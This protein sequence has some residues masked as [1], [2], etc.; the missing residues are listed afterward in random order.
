MKNRVEIK[1]RKE[2]IKLVDSFYDKVNRDELLSPVFNDFSRVDWE[3]HLPVMYN[4]WCSML[5]GEMSYKGA[6]FQK[7]IPLPI[8][9]PHFDRWLYLFNETVDE[10]FAGT[11]AEEAKNRAANIAK[12]FELKLASIQITNEQQHDRQ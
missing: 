8:S 2:I 12:I 11:L 1:S 4:F 5:L 9:K 7:H 6:P 3:K 10:L